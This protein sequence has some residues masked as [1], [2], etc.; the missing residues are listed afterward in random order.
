M[1]YE[2]YDSLTTGSLSARCWIGFIVRL[3]LGPSSK[4]AVML[5]IY[6]IM[7]LSFP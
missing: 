6:E 4:D 1:R 3:A 2:L 5:C 7:F